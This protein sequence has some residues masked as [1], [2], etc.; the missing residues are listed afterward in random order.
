MYEVQFSNHS[1]KFISNLNSKRKNQIKKA[2]DNL[3]KDP[4]SY[5]Y[6]KLKDFEAD[7]RIRVGNFRITY[8]VHKKQL[9]IRIIKIGKR[10]NFYS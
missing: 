2:I 5:P 1:K 6:K 8:S 9:L 3:R 10:E 7:Y 4:F